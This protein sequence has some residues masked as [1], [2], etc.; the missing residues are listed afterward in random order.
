MASPQATKSILA[1]TYQAEQRDS[2]VGT[3]YILQ[4][5]SP[6][7]KQQKVSLRKKGVARFDQHRCLKLPERAVATSLLEEVNESSKVTLPQ[8]PSAQPY[9]DSRNWRTGRQQTR[10][11]EVVAPV[12][13]DLEFKS[14]ITLPRLRRGS[15]CEDAAGGGSCGST[16]PPPA[17]PLSARAPAAAA[18]VGSPTAAAGVPLVYQVVLLGTTLESARSSATAA[19][20][21]AVSQVLGL[22]A[23][24]AEERVREAL[25]QR[26]VSLACFDAQ[27]SAFDAAHG[28]RQR[29]LRVQ[30]VSQAGLPQRGQKSRRRRRSKGE[31]RDGGYMEVFQNGM[32]GSILC[33]KHKVPFM[34]LLPPLDGAEAKPATSSRRKRLQQR[35]AE[36]GVRGP[37]ASSPNL[38]ASRGNGDE[39]DG[40]AG[41]TAAAGASAADELPAGG[42]EGD[43][44]ARSIKVTIAKSRKEAC[45][46]FRVLVFGSVGNENAKTKEEKEA[47]YHEQQG[48][49]EQVRVLQGFWKKLDDDN[50]GRVDLSEFRR[51]VEEQLR[52][53]LAQDAIPEW[54]F[55][56][57]GV[58][59]EKDRQKIVFKY[60][61]RVAQ[62]IMGKKSSFVFQD[63][64]RVCYPSAG[65]TDLH[66]MT[67][68][69]KELER[70]A[71][72]ARV[73][74]PPVLDQEIFDGL[75]SVFDWFD[76]DN[77]GELMF[78]E[79]VLRGL[80]Y[81]DQIEA[82]RRDWDTNGDG[83]LCVHEFCDMMCPLGYRAY[84][85][86]K[87]GS[88]KDGTRLVLNVNNSTWEIAAPPGGAG[89]A[90]AAGNGAASAA[91]AGAAAGEGFSRQRS[92]DQPTPTAQTQLRERSVTDL[93]SGSPGKAEVVRERSATESLPA[94]TQGTGADA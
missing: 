9:A 93:L 5:V 1:G 42:A 39:E 78:D 86:S 80:I 89:A 7:H 33:E 54:V 21:A 2:L 37:G 83:S 49:K 32:K 15:H 23:E 16:A 10:L 31:S 55:A 41:A 74:T 59:I 52:E 68:W 17:A 38:D 72:L 70:M 87:V 84:A 26:F 40:G 18:E 36:G 48:S 88:L 8:L 62:A 34:N 61:D 63:L 71:N 3:S 46:L 79:L 69:C 85:N 30:V 82:Y 22:T 81:E 77:S 45:Q 11:G 24:A 66:V 51:D 64:L 28:L 6:A 50:S 65:Q 47:I 20:T 56:L 90:A 91:A 67:K 60:V 94:P 43:A 73:K 75:C 58:D 4:A 57:F 29:G 53:M 12:P 13:T 76:E 92:T 27:A 14:W 19:A 44:P 35:G 25:E